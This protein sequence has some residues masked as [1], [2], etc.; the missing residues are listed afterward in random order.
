MILSLWCFFVISVGDS[1]SSSDPI[2]TF[3]RIFITERCGAGLVIV[4]E[5]MSVTNATHEQA[6]V[7][8]NSYSLVTNV[9]E[10]YIYCPILIGKILNILFQNA[11]KDSPATTAAAVP[12]SPAADPASLSPE[13]QQHMV[14]DFSIKSGMNIEFS[15][16]CLS[17]CNWDYNRAAQAFTMANEKGQIPPEAFVKELQ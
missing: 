2:R 6:Q 13:Q 5:Q 17:E 16:R 8:T 4:N 14:Q 12:T 7:T 15:L 1:R 11:F 10:I 9:M 3:S